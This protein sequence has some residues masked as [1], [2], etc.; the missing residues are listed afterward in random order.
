VTIPEYATVHRRH[1]RVETTIATLLLVVAVLS[2]IGFIVQIAKPQL[3]DN[4]SWDGNNRLESILGLVWFISS[5]SATIVSRTL[6]SP[7]RQ[8]IFA[9]GGLL[10]ILSVFSWFVALGA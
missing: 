9:G 1:R 5:L 8:I 10:T 6:H 2:L 4:Q 7:M 3:A